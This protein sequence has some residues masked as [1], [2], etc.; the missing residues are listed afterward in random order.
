M[1]LK[2][3]L[4]GLEIV[5]VAPIITGV[6]FV[7]TLHMR[8]ISVI[9]PYILQSSLLFYHIIIIIIIIIIFILS[10]ILNYNTSSTHSTRNLS[11]H[12]FVRLPPSLTPLSSPCTSHSRDTMLPFIQ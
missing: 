5:P 2:Y 7:S 3:F 4:K 6:T 9:N 8:S 1:L 11:P 12:L 10:L